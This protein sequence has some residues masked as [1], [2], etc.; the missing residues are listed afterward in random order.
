M[1]AGDVSEWTEEE[2]VDKEVV[3]YCDGQGAED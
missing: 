2:G 1:G 3:D